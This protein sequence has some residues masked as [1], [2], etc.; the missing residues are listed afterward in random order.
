VTDS[1]VQRAVVVYTR[2]P[3]WV[4]GA[5]LGEQRGAREHIAFLVAGYGEG[6]VELAGPFH[7]LEDEVPDGALVGLV[8]YQCN[9]TV[10]ASRTEEDPAVRSGLLGFHVLPWY[11]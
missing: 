10:A 9:A 11:A 4:D 5:P 1:V 6:V 7:R 8:V 2:G 3:E